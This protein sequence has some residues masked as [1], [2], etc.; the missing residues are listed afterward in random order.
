MGYYKKNYFSHYSPNVNARE[1]K[2]PQGTY[3]EVTNSGETELTCLE[4]KILRC[5]RSNAKTETRI[6]KEIKVNLPTVSQ[7]I[8]ELMLKGFLQRTRNRRMIFFPKKDSFSTTI[9]G[10][11]ALER[12]QRNGS[13]RTFL[14]QVLYMV[15]D[16]SHRIVEEATP[17]SLTLKLFFGTLRLVYQ[18]TKYALSK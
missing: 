7:L 12:N 18:V 2:F 17:D 11:M 6:S 15:K 8:T 13:N 4:I 14:S 10:L 3:C 9:E 1:T 16:S 5:T